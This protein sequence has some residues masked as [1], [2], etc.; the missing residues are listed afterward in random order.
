MR[1]VVLA[2][3][4]FTAAREPSSQARPQSGSTGAGQSALS[5]SKVEK[6]SAAQVADRFLGGAKMIE[7]PEG[8]KLVSE[9]EWP[10]RMKVNFSF[11]VFSRY[12]TVFEGLFDTDVGGIQGYKRLVDI[13][14][15]R[16]GGAALTERFT[17][18]LYQGRADKLWRVIA[19]AKS[20]DADKAVDY[21]RRRAN[22]ETEDSGYNRYI[23]GLS[24]IDAGKLGEARET[25]KKALSLAEA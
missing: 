17:L 22:Q 8:K 5:V 11:P 10:I 18:I 16:E 12:S 4:L 13:E 7:M 2:V 14:G 15:R 6:E 1:Y 20:Q 9:T 3:L 25:F 24:L 19:F 21:F 23:L